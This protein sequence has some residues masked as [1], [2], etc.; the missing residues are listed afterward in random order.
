MAAAS[1]NTQE[2]KLR[3][4]SMPSLGEAAGNNEPATLDG[5]K[6]SLP[7]I[8]CKQLGINLAKRKALQMVPMLGAAVGSAMNASFMYD[9]GQTAMRLYQRKWLADNGK[10]G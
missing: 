9:V 2:E 8:L 7:G 3:A 5:K 4:L 10:W 6:A 1:A